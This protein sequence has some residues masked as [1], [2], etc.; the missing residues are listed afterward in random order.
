MKI[1]GLCGGK[2][3]YL[4]TDSNCEDKR[5]VRT[6]IQTRDWILKQ[7]YFLWNLVPAS[8]KRN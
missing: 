4:N 3:L 8:F 5:P 6:R 2:D 7:V 1:K